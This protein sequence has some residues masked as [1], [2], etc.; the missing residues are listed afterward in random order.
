MKDERHGDGKAVLGVAF[1]R[2]QGKDIIFN[3]RVPDGNM[4]SQD[5]ARMGPG[6]VGEEENNLHLAVVYRDGLN[7]VHV[8]A[9]YQLVREGA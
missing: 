8:L 2:L 7:I 5:D 4:L 6:A 3:A 1:R 9:S